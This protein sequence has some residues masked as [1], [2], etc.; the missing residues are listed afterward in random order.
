MERRPVASRAA[1]GRATGL[2]W[3]STYVL[4]AAGDAAMALWDRRL[5]LDQVEERLAAPTRLSRKQIEGALGPLVARGYLTADE[6]PG[7]PET[8]V[9]VLSKG[10]EE[11]CYRFVPGYARLSRDVL[12]LVCQDAGADVVGLAQRSGQAELL[13]E[14]VLVIAEGHGLL[15]L[16]GTGQYVVVQEVRPQLR[17][18]ISGAA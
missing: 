9:Q 18:W 8:V 17:R 5:T 14:H 4:K 13:V 15:R 7:N 12:G 16:G 3:V 11:Y 10:L 2:D 1:V 6:A